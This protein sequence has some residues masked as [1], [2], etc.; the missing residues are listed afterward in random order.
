MVLMVYWKYFNLVCILTSKRNLKG[1]LCLQG[2]YLL[3]ASNDFA[4]R[5]WTVDDNRLRVS[6][7]RQSSARLFPSS[8]PSFVKW[9]HGSFGSWAFTDTFNSFFFFV[10]RFFISGRP[11]QQDL[12]YSFDLL[13]ALQ[14]APVTVYFPK[15]TPTRKTLPHKVCVHFL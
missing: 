3:A 10:E 8:I 6:L 12:K 5:I 4:S 9:G 13:T 2:S 7:A 11:S 1:I 15:T 14:E